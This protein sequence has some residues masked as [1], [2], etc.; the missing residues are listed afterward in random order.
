MWAWNSGHKFARLDFS[1]TGNPRG[2]TV[3]LGSTGCMPNDT[4]DT[5]PTSCSSP[6]RV[7]VSFPLFDPSR[8]V[9]I[10]DLGRLLQDTNVDMSQNTPPPGKENE[11]RTSASCMS[12]PH[13]GD[14]IGLFANFGLPFGERPGSE[15]KFFR[16]GK[17]AVPD[18]PARASK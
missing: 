17:L 9:V 1:S 4:R 15:Q 5:I 6:N 18:P 11:P 2:F 14:C 12:G 8:Q 7:Q 3:H 16:V 13:S 10:A